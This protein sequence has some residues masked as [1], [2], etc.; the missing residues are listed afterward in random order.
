MRS[1]V[2]LG[3]VLA[4]LVTACGGGRTRFTSTPR[5]EIEPGTPPGEREKTTWEGTVSKPDEPK[6]SSEIWHAKAAALPGQPASSCQ[7]FRSHP[8]N[9]AACATHCADLKVQ[10]LAC[11]CG[12]GP[13]P[14]P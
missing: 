14:K 9:K 11:T 8:D 6:A 12:D 7:S 3:A 1:I 10:V 4:L 13:C 5:T 2:T